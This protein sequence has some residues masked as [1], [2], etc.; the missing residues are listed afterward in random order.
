MESSREKPE[1]KI[2]GIRALWRRELSPGVANVFEVVQ[3]KIDERE[4]S[5]EPVLSQ[6]LEKNAL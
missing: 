1:V 4:D 5:L 6:R 2:Q 3:G